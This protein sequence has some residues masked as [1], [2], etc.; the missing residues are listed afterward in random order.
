MLRLGGTSSQLQDEMMHMISLIIG[1]MN[2]RIVMSFGMS[3]KL[4]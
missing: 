3:N 2:L 1:L 4:V